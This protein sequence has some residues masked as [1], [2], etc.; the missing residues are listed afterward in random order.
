MI[1]PLTIG[2]FNDS[3]PPAID[4]VA[5]T[6]INYANYF[7]R[8][9]GCCYAVVPYFPNGCKEDF[10]FPVLNFASIPVPFRKG[11]RFFHPGLNLKLSSK[12]THI[13]FDILHAH[14]PFTSGKIALNLA[15]KRDIPIVATFHTKFRDDIMAVFKSDS[16]ADRMIDH[17]VAFYNQC[18][19]VWVVNQST[20]R[21]LEEYGYKKEYMIAPN[22]CDFPIEACTDEIR[23]TINRTYNIAADQ[24]LILFVGQLTFQKNTKRIIQSIKELKKYDV[25]FKMMFAGDGAKR[26]Y[27]E[28]MADRLGLRN[29]V[30]F[31]GSIADRHLLNSIYKRADLFLFPSIYDNAPLVVREAAACHTPSLLVEGSNAAEGIIDNENG[32]LVSRPCEQ[33]I[34]KRIYDIF[35]DEGKLHAVAQRA[36]ETVCVPWDKVLHDVHQ[37][38]RA[39]I[40]AYRN[41]QRR[42]I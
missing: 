42:A 38:Y 14:S 13:D 16:I 19:A 26:S 18:D 32:Y 10:A 34:S 7:H 39:I 35:N 4:G 24:K 5:N 2:Q 31:A 6:V 40:H 27:L 11:Y 36:S 3:F 28:E 12:L 23:D 22:G 41:E 9:E 25:D 29:D 1:D 37:Q 15:K 30:I 21:T 33:E 8:E 17:I 20:G